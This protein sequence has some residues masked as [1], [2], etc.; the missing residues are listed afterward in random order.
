MFV[1]EAGG[2]MVEHSGHNRLSRAIIADSVFLLVD[3][4]A[5]V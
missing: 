3:E 2:R 4:E 5:S 1:A